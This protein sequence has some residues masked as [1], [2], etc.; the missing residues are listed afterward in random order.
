MRSR[1]SRPDAGVLGRE[2]T[3]DV[4]RVVPEIGDDDVSDLMLQAQLTQADARLESAKSDREL[5]IRLSILLVRVICDGA[6]KFIAK[7]PDGTL[8]IDK[9][10]FIDVPKN[11]IIGKA[12][13]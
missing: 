8:L 5:Y 12:I 7:A 4:P 6:A 1:W 11:W 10:A 13:F 9:E 2:R 3:R